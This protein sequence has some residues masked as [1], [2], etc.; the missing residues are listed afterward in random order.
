MMENNFEVLM[1]TII[2]VSEVNE[3]LQDIIQDLSKRGI[4]HD[5]TKFQDPEYSM[6][7]S[8]RPEFKKANFGTPEYEAVTKK[9]QVAVN[10]H[11]KHNRHHTGFHENGVK[12][13][14]LM[15]L[16]E[17]LADWKAASRRSPDLTFEDSL[18]RAFKKYNMD[19]ALQQAIRNT[20]KYLEW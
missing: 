12:D 8:T 18:P 1:D 15:D 7:C 20:I 2:H 9:A 17:M 11:Y 4:S 6:F 10:H 19:E 13:M 5:R 14:N 3:N 16:L